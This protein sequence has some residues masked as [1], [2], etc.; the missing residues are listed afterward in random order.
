MLQK[1][2]ATH[3]MNEAS[4]R[5][6]VVLQ[7]SVTSVPTAA[8]DEQRRA[9]L[10]LV[11][12]AGCERQ[13]LTG[14]QPTPRTTEDDAQ[15]PDL[16]TRATQAESIAIN[17]SLMVLRQVI[18]ARSALDSAKSHSEN[19]AKHQRSSGL[20][21]VPY[22]DS[23]LTS[24]LKSGLSGSGRMVMIAC[25]APS[26]QHVE[27]TMSSLDYA[28]LVRTTVCLCSALYTSPLLCLQ[29]TI[30]SVT[31]LTRLLLA[32]H[33]HGNMVSCRLGESTTRQ[34]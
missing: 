32:V 26:Q 22:R 7:L 4:S 2:V 20:A 12:L 6:H 10:V 15:H 33:A 3:D 8:K 24:L 11:D 30:S 18:A 13:D 14:I 28:C 5:S 23:K 34:K 31:A 19:S 25:I 9:N 1:A 17:K 21:H 29:C 16:S 27:G